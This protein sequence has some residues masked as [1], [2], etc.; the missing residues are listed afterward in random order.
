MGG[1]QSGE[2]QLTPPFALPSKARLIECKFCPVFGPSAPGRASK[3]GFNVQNPSATTMMEGNPTLS[4]PGLRE[5]GRVRGLSAEGPSDTPAWALKPSSGAE[6]Q[7]PPIEVCALPCPGFRLLVRSVRKRQM[8]APGGLWRTLTLSLVASLVP[9]KCCHSLVWTV[10]GKGVRKLCTQRLATLALVPPRRGARKQGGLT[11]LQSKGAASLA[12]NK[13]SLNRGQI[14]GHH[15]LWPPSPSWGTSSEGR[16]LP[17]TVQSLH[18]YVR[19][20]LGAS[21]L[22]FII[23]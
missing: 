6:P 5:L 22:S 15:C 9:G 18:T 20:H 10:L 19:K 16:F 12:T 23:K 17:R 7:H 3:K 1:G 11:A 2:A 14:P 8:S 21:R 4:S 13:G